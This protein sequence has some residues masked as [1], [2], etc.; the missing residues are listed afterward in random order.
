MLRV[1]DAVRGELAEP[2]SV[3]RMAEVAAMSEAHFARRFRE[4]IGESPSAWLRHQRVQRAARLVRTTED[5]IAEIAYTVGF[6]SAARLT[7]AFHR[8][9]AT[10][11][12]AWRTEG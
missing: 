10:T 6:S 4:H 11:P 12:T 7:E 1:V 9:F 8:H 5:T 3:A 2:W